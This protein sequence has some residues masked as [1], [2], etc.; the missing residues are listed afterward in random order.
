M[1]LKTTRKVREKT[2]T[3]LSVFI[4]NSRN[5]S[6]KKRTRR[7]NQKARINASCVSYTLD[8]HVVT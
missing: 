6:D 5:Q 2:L 7:M 4:I 1:N 3:H 8:L